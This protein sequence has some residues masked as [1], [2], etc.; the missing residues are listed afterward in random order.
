M[1]KDGRKVSAEEARL[2]Q[3]AMRDAKPAGRRPAG[4]SAVAAKPKPGRPPRQTAVPPLP[5]AEDGRRT[6]RPDVKRGAT[7]GLDRRSAERFRRG[8]LAVEARLDLH[9]M[10]QAQAHRTLVRFVEDSAAAGRRT[11]LVITG[12]G[13]RG[14][15][16]W[17]GVL[18]DAV[19]RWLSTPPLSDCVLQIA[20]A[21]QRDGGL[22]AFYVRLRRR[23]R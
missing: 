22:G 10:T 1:A 18:R 16:D 14:A 9:G 21:K 6:A 17:S 2:W 23:R 19:P 11:L 3:Q 5:A 8:Q 7:P 15:E 12:K 4:D 20:P 13:G